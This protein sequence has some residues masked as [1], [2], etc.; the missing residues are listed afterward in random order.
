[1][2]S[3]P[4]TKMQGLGNDFVV[5]EG[6]DED[7]SALAPALCD[8]RSGVGAD[9]VLVALASGT[10]DLR[11]RMFNP[12][13]TEDECGNGVRC[14]ALYARLRGLV[15]ADVFRLET[16]SG[17]KTVTVQEDP[18]IATPGEAQRPQGA[19]LRG[20]S[21]GLSSL[22]TADLG[23]ARLEPAAIPAMFSGPTA[24]GAELEVG[25]ELLEVHSLSTGTAHTIIFEMPDEERFQRLSPLLEHHPTY[26]ERT[27]VMWT[28]IVGPDHVRV[29]IWERAVGETLA[30]GTGAGAVAVASHLSGRTGRRVSVTSPGGT[31]VIDIGEGLFLRQTGPAAVVYEGR[32]GN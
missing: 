5:V 16:I 2:M 28:E 6:E 4:F 27:S 20:D 29:R 8:R 7:W 14:V 23:Q 21:D 13:G 30:C 26:P 1:M 9:G 25:G 22:V 10:A 31:L 11:M 12:D 15:P 18:L 32:W 17:V 19:M 3:F 24:L